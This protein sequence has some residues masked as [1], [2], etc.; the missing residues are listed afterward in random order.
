MVGFDLEGDEMLKEVRGL[1]GIGRDDGVGIIAVVEAVSTG[2]C[3]GCEGL[4][5]VCVEVATWAIG[6]TDG[7]LSGAVARGG[8]ISVVEGTG[9]ASAK[10]ISD[11]VGA[12]NNNT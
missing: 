4:S 3:G 2:I 6:S 11:P 9:T 7:N 12:L 5:G 10:G 1:V 8:E